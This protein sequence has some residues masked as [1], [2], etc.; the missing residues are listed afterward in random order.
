MIFNCKSTKW[1]EESFFNLP[2][3]F[4]TRRRLNNYPP[5]MKTSPLRNETSGLKS[6]E[7]QTIKCVK[8]ESCHH[9][10]VFKS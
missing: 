10:S 2:R 4:G 7:N 1:S 3:K 6:K 8:K 9:Q 5:L